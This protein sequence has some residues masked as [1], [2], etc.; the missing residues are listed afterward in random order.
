MSELTEENI[1]TI[2][3]G[4]LKANF[5]QNI[6][7]DLRSVVKLTTPYWDDVTFAF[8][9]PINATRRA[10]HC[11]EQKKCQH[12]GPRHR[13]KHVEVCNQGDPINSRTIKMET[14]RDALNVGNRDT[15]ITDVI[16]AVRGSTAT[17]PGQ[18]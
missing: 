18:H 8:E 9:M 10:E 5:L 4:V 15:G 14:S 11:T 7:P 17:I 12:P 13:S 3:N 2:N 6:L 1:G 16:P